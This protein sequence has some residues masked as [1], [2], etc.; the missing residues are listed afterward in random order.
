MCGVHVFVC[1]CLCMCACVCVY[2]CMH[3]CVC[4]CMCVCLYISAANSL[5]SPS[6]LKCHHF[7]IFSFVC[8]FFLFDV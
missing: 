2:V 7:R 8:G 4:V 6:V 1:V 5:E 3:V